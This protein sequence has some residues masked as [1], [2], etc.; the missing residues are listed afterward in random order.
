MKPAKVLALLLAAILLLSACTS[1]PPAQETP[2]VTESTA[3]ST[4]PVTE[5]P[6]T[7]SPTEPTH[8][9]TGEPY[10]PEEKSITTACGFPSSDPRDVPPITPAS[11]IGSK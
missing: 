10:T 5:P 8:D 4:E 11:P 7:T 9:W 1:V 2:P 3:P 6:P